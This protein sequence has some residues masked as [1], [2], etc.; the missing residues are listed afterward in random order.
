[1]RP[2]HRL[3]SFPPQQVLKLSDG[4]VLQI[5]QFSLSTKASALAHLFSSASVEVHCVGHAVRGL[6]CARHSM[7]TRH[8][9]RQLGML[10][11]KP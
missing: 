6:G 11:A 10:P 4:T 5:E 2:P 8:A 7:R 3:P 9:T 1:M